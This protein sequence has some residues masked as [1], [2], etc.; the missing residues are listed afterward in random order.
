M[1]IFCWS[2][3][4]YHYDEGKGKRVILKGLDPFIAEDKF[5]K[6]GRLAEEQLAFYLRRAFVDDEDIR[7]FNNLRFEHNHDAAQIDHLILHPYGM[8]I[9]E[10]KSVT[11]KVEINEREEWIRWFDNMPKGMPSPIQQAKIQG[12]FLKS[13]LNQFAPALLGKALIGQRYFGGMP[14]DYIVAISDSGIIERPKTVSLEEVCKADQVPEKVRNTFDKWKKIN[15]FFSLSSEKGYVFFKEEITNL[16]KF[17]IAKN[18]PLLPQTSPKEATAAKPAP[19]SLTLERE[20]LESSKD[21]LRSSYSKPSI[22]KK[23]HSEPNKTEP[24]RLC[25]HCNSS[26]LFIEYGFNY[27]F[28]CLKCEKNIPIKST[29]LVCKENEKIR[30][31]G[32]EFYLG[33]AQCKTS[34]LFYTNPVV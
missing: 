13:Y 4:D 10:S 24:I 8:I 32:R 33:C 2:G 14:I 31:K 18:K 30:K 22:I 19:R 11:T 1:R 16:N 7:V 28:K 27:Y 29:C 5:A 17:L 12:E 15:N 6:A 20:I 34:K 3:E 23:Q 9:I 25:G 26:N 21:E